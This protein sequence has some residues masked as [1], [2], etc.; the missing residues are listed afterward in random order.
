MYVKGIAMD[1]HCKVCLEPW[2]I[3]SLHEE[4]EERE[5]TF[6]EVYAEFR[7]KGCEAFSYGK[8]NKTLQD[9]P[10]VDSERE[11]ITML[12][13]LIGDDVDAIAVFE[14]DFL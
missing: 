5:I 8:H 4:A 12:Q 3:D 1:I 2:D 9:E 13:D 10:M 7:V 6:E 11:T 14:E